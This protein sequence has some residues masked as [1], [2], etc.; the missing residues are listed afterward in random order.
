MNSVTMYSNDCPK[1][2]ILETKFKSAKINYAKITDQEQI[3]KKASEN[4]ISS[5]PFCI[6][7][8]SIKN[9]LQSINWINNRSE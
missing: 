8:G 1:C 5:M 3:C 9:Y 7:D 4:Q 2:K 6:I